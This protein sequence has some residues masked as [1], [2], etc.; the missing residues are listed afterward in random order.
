MRWLGEPVFSK[1]E[2]A[3]M[4]A[5]PKFSAS[6]TDKPTIVELISKIQ[7]F[8]RGQ[9]EGTKLFVLQNRLEG[10]LQENV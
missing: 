3:Q 4:E 2:Q 9:P 5:I 1:T 7:A 6:P 8:T 10:L